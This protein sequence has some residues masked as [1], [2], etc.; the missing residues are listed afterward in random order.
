MEKET[1]MSLTIEIQGQTSMAWVL[2]T[3]CVAQIERL[4]ATEARALLDTIFGDAETGAGTARAVDRVVVWE[5]VRGLRPVAKKLPNGFEVR[6]P[7]F[8]RRVMPAVKRASPLGTRGAGGVL[9]GGKYHLIMCYDDYWT[10]QAA[11][12]VGGGKDPV[13]HYEPAEIH[14]ENMGLVQIHSKKRR[15]SQLAKAL[16]GMQDFLEHD[17]SKDVTVIWG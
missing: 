14:S 10:I 11:D 16:Q 3:V 12:D 15:P 8:F 2:S 6:M 17:R 9:I 1:G 4:R 7:D 5:A 13:R